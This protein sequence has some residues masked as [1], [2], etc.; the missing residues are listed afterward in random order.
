MFTPRMTKVSGL[1]FF[2]DGVPLSVAPP[3]LREIRLVDGVGT[4][5]IVL[6][7]DNCF[8]GD[9]S[10]EGSAIRTLFVPL[11]A[12]T[13]GE[14]RPIWVPDASM[15]TGWSDRQRAMFRMRPR[16]RLFD[17]PDRESRNW[18][19]ELYRTTPLSHPIILAMLPPDDVPPT[20][21][22]EGGRY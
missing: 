3:A 9:W 14:K 10:N 21:A 17:T 4:S 6:A 18:W 19:A 20:D 5:R 15:Q 13:D 22:V 16:A 8:A 2:D 1:R 7:P 11:G 12:C